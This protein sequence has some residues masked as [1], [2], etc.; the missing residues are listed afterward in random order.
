[1]QRQKNP[2]LMAALP[3][4]KFFR[5][6]MK[7]IIKNMQK[8]HIFLDGLET[9]SFTTHMFAICII[10]R[11]PALNKEGPWNKQLK[12]A[13]KMTNICLTCFPKKS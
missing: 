9:V 1:M 2:C 12:L 10:N 3:P 7:S 13:P 5:I 4:R 11:K 8:M 6:V